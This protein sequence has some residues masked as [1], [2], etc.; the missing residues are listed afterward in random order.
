MEHITIVTDRDPK[1]TI[2]I[3]TR[4]I[5]DE[6]SKKTKLMQFDH[7]SERFS[8]SLPR[9]VE[10]HDMLECDSVQVHFKN[11]ALTDKTE[12]V[13]RYDIDDLQIDPEDET[14][15][16]CTWLIS[17]AVTSQFGSLTFNLH[18][19]CHDENGDI[20][21]AWHTDRFTGISISE[22]LENS[23]EIA[24][25]YADVLEQWKRGFLT[26]DNVSENAENIGI[27]SFSF[28]KN[29]IAG[30][31]G[32]YFK[33][34]DPVNK[35]I[36]LLT[37][38][39]ERKVAVML[40]EGYNES[41]Y[42]DANCELSAKLWSVGDNLSFHIQLHYHFCGVTFNSIE[43]N[44]IKYDGELPFDTINALSLENPWHYMLANPDKPLSGD[45]IFTMANLAIGEETKALGENAFSGGYGSIAVG[46]YATALGYLCIAGY[47]A[48]AE[49]QKT[50]ALGEASHS[51]GMN[52]KAN[53]HNSH[54]Q[55][56]NTEANGNFSSAHGR[57]TKAN[58]IA[59]NSNGQYTEANGDYSESH[60]E[61]TKANGKGSD[62]G[63]FYSES[64]GD[65]A[66]SRGERCKANGKNAVAIGYNTIASGLYAVALN[67]LTKA[68]NTG[69][70]ALGYGTIADGQYQLVAGRF[71]KNASSM[72]FILG[73]GTNDTDRK[74]IMTVDR[75]GNAIIAG[76]VST[77]AVVLKSPSGK[78]FKL[79]VSDT[80]ELTTVAV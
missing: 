64:N 16:I 5:I 6:S 53:G 52:T 45:D 46:N 18:F 15:V 69:A 41:D 63:G 51:E 34:I 74:N 61:Y 47:M 56:A 21:Y 79:T 70:T 33:A 28:G 23:E 4:Q 30:W 40:D 68:T 60:N 73:W 31:S 1:F 65:Y 71:N 38:G 22:G 29:N 44:R 2:D 78:S 76:N 55:N 72:V 20:S 11:V 14:K 8:F 67:Y 77:P 66:F 62:A 25:V 12:I 17:R 57:N 36:Y 80:G 9:Y 49:G 48:T 3:N 58:G 32:C 10:N 7:N 42:F 59:S 35:Y 50:R 19:V 54:A 37:P 75:N 13:G 24:T 43:G 27:K 26:V 39:E